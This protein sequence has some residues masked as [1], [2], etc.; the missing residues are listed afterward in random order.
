MAKPDKAALKKEGEALKVIVAQARKKTLNF[1][2]LQG[3]DGMVLETHLKKNPEMLRKS[4]KKRGGGPK[5]ALGQLRVEG[6]TMVFLVTE[7]PPGPFVKLTRQFLMARGLPMQVV[8]K[9]PDGTA[10]G[11]DADFATAEPAPQQPE[12]TEAAA[13]A[14][15]ASAPQEA[16]VEESVFEDLFS[17]LSESYDSLMSDYEKAKGGLEEKAHSIKDDM[18]AWYRGSMLGKSVEEAKQDIREFSDMI[19]AGKKRAMVELTVYNLDLPEAEKDALKEIATTRPEVYEATLKA[20]E[21]I[22][23]GLA[24]LEVSASALEELKNVQAKAKALS[25]KKWAALEQ[26]QNNKVPFAKALTPAENAIPKAEDSLILAEARLDTFQKKLGQLS[27]ERKQQ[28]SPEEK[29]KLAAKLAALKAGIGA[30]K[31]ALEAAKLA[32][33][34]AQIKFDEV[35]KIF[36]TLNE[37]V[38]SVT[39]K[40][41][42]A[43]KAVEEVAFA[44]K[45][46]KNLTRSLEAGMLSPLAPNPLSASEVQTMI[47]A[48]GASPKMGETARELL[49][50]A[51][52][53]KNLL[54]GVT[55]LTNGAKAGFPDK[56]GNIFKGDAGQ[57]A[58]KALQMGVALGGDYFADMNRFIADGGLNKPDPIALASIDHMD[59]PPQA[60]ARYMG[61]AMLDAN[62]KIDPK[63]Q[64]AQAAFDIVNFHPD[65]L[66][67]DMR[68]MNIHFVEMAKSMEDPARK[69]ACQA[70]L[71]SVALPPLPGVDPNDMSDEAVNKRAELGWKDT[72][73]R[74]VSKGL[75]KDP[76]DV[77]NDDVKSA[78]MSAM[79]TPLDQSDSGSC[80]ATGPARQMRQK[81]PAKTMRDMIEIATKGTFTPAPQGR[82]MPAPIPAVREQRIQ[83]SDNQL[84]R[85]WEYSI[86][87]AGAQ[88]ARSYEKNQLAEQLFDNTGQDLDG[89]KTLMPAGTDWTAIRAKLEADVRAQ[90]T[91]RYNAISVQEKASD[92]KSSKGNFEIQDVATKKMITT[93][94]DF[95][96]V[97]TRIALESTGYDAASETGQKIVNFCKSSAFIA[98][99]CKNDSIP[100]KIESGGFPLPMIKVLD[101]PGH[102][103]ST[104]ASYDESANKSRGALALDITK[105]VLGQLAKMGPDT[106]MVPIT[107]DLHAF[108]ALPQDPSLAPLIADSDPA[109]IEKAIQD[110]LLTPGKKIAETKMPKAKARFLFMQSLD[111]AQNWKLDKEGFE[112]LKQAYKNA[113]TEDLL[114][115]DVQS[116]IEKALAPVQKKLESLQIEAWKAEQRADSKTITPASLEKQKKTLHQDLAKKIEGRFMAEAIIQLGEPQITFADTNWGDDSSH[117][118]FVMIPD[119]T[120]GTLRLFAKKEPNG[121]LGPLPDTWLK[122]DWDTIN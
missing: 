86:A 23:A 105:S 111:A 104:L 62:G 5:A 112:L 120:T 41:E 63:S 48:Y 28:L 43:N 35:S 17:G 50:K 9:L 2:L 67:Q 100:W 11:T 93:E 72:G 56:D 87:T 12:T 74:L 42:K 57:Y 22:D 79:F 99:I 101:G 103:Q 1:A 80:F 65:L 16:P 44:L 69:A 52:D 60:A 25:E 94:A 70:A 4:A 92:G 116:C 77:T 106:K 15:A 30:A 98:A 6:K 75:G 24:P 38:F 39:E 26:A 85:S 13:P 10:F 46:K 118:Y 53:R 14:S 58:D 110:T 34:E 97:I 61:E 83:G 82:G 33:A 117:T 121:G 102:Q 81:N 84:M 49:G 21:S 31:Q 89:L 96:T 113:P 36:N 51:D 19:S 3:K 7:A 90:L 8:F 95:V 20:F 47:S 88:L 64:K 71:D 91:F 59:S 55:T 29:K 122:S 18:T 115:K 76:E 78:V 27:P 32:K 119:P 109:K 108:N 107:N 45:A 114:P 68:G 66:K 40:E 54:I 37:D 73:R